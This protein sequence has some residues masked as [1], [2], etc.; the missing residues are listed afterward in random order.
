M[1]KFIVTILVGAICASCGSNSADAGNSGNGQN[2]T[3]DSNAALNTNTTNIGVQPPATT[4]NLPTGNTST[5]GLN[6]AHGQPGH[7][8]EVAVGAPLNGAPAS[9]TVTPTM[10]QPIKST[11]AP[12]PSVNLP[13]SG[14]SGTARLNPPHGQPGHDCSVEVGKPLKQ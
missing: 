6:P 12:T 13:A 5:A 10:T 9:T 2:K 11:P 4:T 3:N 8:C 1:K 7:R 14:N